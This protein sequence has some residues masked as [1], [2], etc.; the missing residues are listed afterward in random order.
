[1]PIAMPPLSEL[2]G[3]REGFWPHEKISAGP[4]STCGQQG[5]K[6]GNKPDSAVGKKATGRKHRQHD[7][8]HLIIFDDAE[9]DKIHATQSGPFWTSRV[10]VIFTGF[11]AHINSALCSPGP[12]FVQIYA[13]FLGLWYNSLDR[14]SARR[15]ASLA[16]QDITNRT[17]A[18]AR[19]E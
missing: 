9:K 7:N 10:P 18:K 15:K 12:T 14:G 16:T 4:Q 5:K 1:M 2:Q 13:L 11:L 3:R 17:K 8:H 19:P 6:E